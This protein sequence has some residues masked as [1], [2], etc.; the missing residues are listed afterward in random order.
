MPIVILKVRS[1][2]LMQMIFIKRRVHL[3]GT[4]AGS[5]QAWIPYHKKDIDTLEQ[6]Q[7]RATKMVPEQRNL[8]YEEHL[9]KCGLT[10][11][12]RVF[13]KCGYSRDH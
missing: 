6:T 11:L 13:V 1:E 12:D 5:A 4:F 10:T 2:E 3:L 9:K 7:R 8:S